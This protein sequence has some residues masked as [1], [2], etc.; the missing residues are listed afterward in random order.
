MLPQIAQRSRGVSDN[1]DGSWRSFQFGDPNGIP[2]EKI[3]H[4]L[5]SVIGRRGA[6]FC[7]AEEVGISRYNDKPVDLRVENVDRIGK[8]FC[9]AGNQFRREIRVKQKPQRDSRS[10]PAC[11][12]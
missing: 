3:F 7:E 5:C 8:K 4:L 9:E 12:A 11:E 2:A 1:Q 6:L 10:R